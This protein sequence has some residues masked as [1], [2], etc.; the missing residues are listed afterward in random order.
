[1]EASKK[2]V[3]LTIGNCVCVLERGGGVSTERGGGTTE[4]GEGETLSERGGRTP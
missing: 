2:S 1:M 4:A 3:V